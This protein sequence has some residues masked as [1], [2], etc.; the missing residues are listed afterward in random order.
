MYDQ[1]IGKLKIRRT[2]TLSGTLSNSYAAEMLYDLA[3]FEG[4]VTGRKA[5]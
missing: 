4:R 5:N 1:G 2:G 3:S